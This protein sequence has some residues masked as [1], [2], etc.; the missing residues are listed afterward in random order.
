MW[1]F[2][3]ICY[4]FP[5]FSVIFCRF[6][7]FAI[8]FRHFLSFSVDFAE[9]SVIFCLTNSDHCDY[10]WWWL[11]LWRCLCFNWCLSY[12]IR[13][14]WICI[15]ESWQLENSIFTVSRQIGNGPFSTKIS[16][17][18]QICQL[19]KVVQ[20]CIKSSIQLFLGIWDHLGPFCAHLNQF[21]QKTQIAIWPTRFGAK[22]KLERWQACNV[23]PLLVKNRAKRFI[24]NLSSNHSTFSQ[25][26]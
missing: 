8:F 24:C 20:I 9:I 14:G 7:S 1:S 16:Q 12:C 17:P 11:L 19:S 3:V 4:H 15:S 18:W 13:K 10:W 26:T 22:K 6:P 2:S 25:A 21:G 5:L 23:W